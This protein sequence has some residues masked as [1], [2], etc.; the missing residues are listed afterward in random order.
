MNPHTISNQPQFLVTYLLQSH[1]KTP[2]NMVI[3]YK[4]KLNVT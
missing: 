1:T 4:V 3:K 2:V